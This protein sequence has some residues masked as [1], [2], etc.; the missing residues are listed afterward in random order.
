MPEDL[1]RPIA[2]IAQELAAGKTTSRKLVEAA[3]ARIATPAA[4]GGAFHQ[5]ARSRRAAR[6][7]RLGPA[8]KGRRGA[9]SA[10]GTARLD[11]GSFRHRG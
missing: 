9:V 10:G 2:A 11:Q 8:A 3:L 1:V 4:E 6:R 7:R 5:G